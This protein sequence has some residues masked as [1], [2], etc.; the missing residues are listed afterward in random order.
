M[1]LLTACCNTHVEV[2]YTYGNTTIR[3][4][5]KCG[6]T[7]FYYNNSKD[8]KEG[9][10]T[11]YSGIDSHFLGWLKFDADGKVWII[12]GD[13]YFIQGENIDT[14]KFQS[15][16][17]TVYDDMPMLGKNIYL[18]QL[19]TRYEREKNRNIGTEVKAVYKDGL[20]E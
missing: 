1:F 18:I 14:T 13:G 19:S 20:D 9:I 8:K 3:R 15:K 16:R 2:T 5:D 11:K 17:P 12:S 6:K 7:F 4:V 10:L